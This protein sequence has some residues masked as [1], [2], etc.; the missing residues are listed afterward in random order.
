M[1]EIII[2]DAGRTAVQNALINS[3]T[4]KPMT[5]KVS[6]VAMAMDRTLTDIDTP[7]HTG[8]ITGYSTPTVHDTEFI[9][10]VEIAD[11][12]DYMTSV[13]LFLDD[14]TMLMFGVLSNP[15]PQG[16]RQV[17]KMMMT[18]TDSVEV[19]DFTYIPL[20]L[21]NYVQFMMDFAED[22]TIDDAV[23]QYNGVT[24]TIPNVA[25]LRDILKDAE[26]LGGHL[27]TYFATTT[28]NHDGTYLGATAVAVDSA[29]LGGQLPA[30]Y[31]SRPYSIVDLPSQGYPDGF[32]TTSTTAI[33]QNKGIYVVEMKRIGNADIHRALVPSYTSDS[34]TNRYVTAIEGAGLLVRV[35]S[36]FTI[37]N[38]D[39]R[40]IRV[41]VIPHS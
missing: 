23:V 5:F 34:V 41:S 21:Q 15:I 12:I 32:P 39:L 31:L 10:D 18:M 8:D 3:T 36:G 40:I 38:S 4:I 25:K 27:P 20:N 37:E 13:G 16:V 2:T 14:G 9:I 1:N 11:A 29:K 6:S 26:M 28:H 22:T 17:F 7:W 35:S 19:V 33:G 24:T 30:Y